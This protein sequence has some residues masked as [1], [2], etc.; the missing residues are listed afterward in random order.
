MSNLM[1]HCGGSVVTRDEVKAVTT[2]PHTKT[3]F[4]MPH[5]EVLDIVQDSLGKFGFE[6]K[7]ERHG[8]SATQDSY[9]G[10]LDLSHPTSSSE[11]YTWAVGI[12]NS[13]DKT[14]SAGMVAGSRVFVCDNLAF[15]GEVKVFRKHTRHVE[16]DFIDM[17]GDSMVPIYNEFI[18]I[19]KR[20]AS[21]KDVEVQDNQ[22][23]DIIIR[24]YDEG[25]IGSR[26]I[27]NVLKEWR[28]PEFEDFQ[29]RDLWSLY[30]AFTFTHLKLGDP[31]LLIKRQTALNRVCDVESGLVLPA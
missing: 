30:N 6:I 23:H 1:M 2:P 11:E 17:V 18:T 12:R 27:P 22:A 21:Y 25:A 16:K 13:H 3:H 28:E 8:L 24:A 4:P 19:D 10:V 5:G 31:R 9:F 26:D 15:S 14:L 29:E 7:S 20:A